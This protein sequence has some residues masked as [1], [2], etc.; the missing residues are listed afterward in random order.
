MSCPLRPKICLAQTPLGLS[1]VAF[2]SL[3]ACLTLCAVFRSLLCIG[4]QPLALHQPASQ[5]GQS[6]VPSK[7]YSHAP[8]L[9][10]GFFGEGRE[11]ETEQQSTKKR[12]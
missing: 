5:G 2:V 9:L 6:A 1:A 12:P 4:F 7:D 3:G 11:A 8:P 10:A